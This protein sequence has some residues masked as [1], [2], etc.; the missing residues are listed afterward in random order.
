MTTR[1]Q[2]KRIK[3]ATYGEYLRARLQTVQSDP[4]AGVVTLHIRLTGIL[5]DVWRSLREVAEGTG[6]SDSDILGLLLRSAVKSVRSSI[7]RLQQG[8]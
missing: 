5:A 1:Q 7:R 2:K 8:L 4:A 6:L 3:Y